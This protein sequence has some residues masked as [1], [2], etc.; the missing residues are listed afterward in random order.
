MGNGKVKKILKGSLDS[1]LSPSEKIQIKY[2]QEIFLEL[3]S[4]NFC[5]TETEGDGIESRLLKYFFT[6]KVSSLGSHCMQCFHE[7]SIELSRHTKA[8]KTWVKHSR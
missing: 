3:F 6:L 4:T 1:I 2:W 8:R 5:F 7:I